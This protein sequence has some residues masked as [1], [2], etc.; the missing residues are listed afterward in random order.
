MELCCNNNLHPSGTRLQASGNCSRSYGYTT[1]MR[2][3]W[4]IR[5]G[6][7]QC[8][9]SRCQM[10]LRSSQSVSFWTLFVHSS[11]C[12][13]KNW[14][15]SFLSNIMICCIKIFLNHPNNEKQPLTKTMQSNMDYIWNHSIN[16]KIACIIFVT[17]LHSVFYCLYVDTS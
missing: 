13:H 15:Q 6:P 1:L 7:H 16:N 17:V 14:K 4:A 12:C 8:S 10:G 5:P 3:C 2:W 9:N 11:N